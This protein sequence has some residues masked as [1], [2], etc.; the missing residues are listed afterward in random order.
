MRSLGDSGGRTKESKISFKSG[1]FVSY[2]GEFVVLTVNRDRQQ[3]TSKHLMRFVHVLYLS[4]PKIIALKSIF[5]LTDDETKSEKEE[6][7]LA[8]L[9]S[10]K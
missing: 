5:D 2:S 8:I 9:K 4:Y 3:S 1:R 6:H 10:N 7:V